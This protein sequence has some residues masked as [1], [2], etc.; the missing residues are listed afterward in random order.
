ME[1]ELDEILSLKYHDIFDYPLTK[2]ELL[3]WKTGRL[4]KSKKENIKIG[5]I[6][7]YFFLK[8]KSS[9]IQKRLLN[10]KYSKYKLKIARKAV[11]VLSRITFIKFVG[12][13]GSLAMNNASKNSDI[14]LMIITTHKRLWLTR[15]IVYLLLYMNKFI[16]RK[17]NSK[18]EKNALCLNMWL[19]DKSLRWSTAWRN[20]YTAHEI[21]QIVPLLNIDETYERFININKW[22]FDYWPNSVVLSKES[23]LVNYYDRKDSKNSFYL[24][25]LLFDL[26]DKISFIFQYLYMKPK[27]TRE[28]V[29][30]NLALF[31]LVDW[32]SKIKN[33]L[34]S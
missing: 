12:I 27:L 11:K 30:P 4:I 19:D 20:I 29:K 6:K 5:K 21:S 25:N 3:K 7:G 18:D 2:S 31:H 24:S 13:T 34:T 22:I 16:L 10:E 1:L 23:K 14:D 9:N 8:G 28:I 26:L 33:Q 17:P 15:S 32:N